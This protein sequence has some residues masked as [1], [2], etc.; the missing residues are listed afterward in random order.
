MLPSGAT[1]RPSGV[2][3][4]YGL[5]PSF[6]PAGGVS[7][8]RMNVPSARNCTITPLMIDDTNHVWSGATT[9]AFGDDSKLCVDGAMNFVRSMWSAIGEPDASFLAQPPFASALDGNGGA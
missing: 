2:P 5:A 4:L 7:T 6:S 1:A 8:V 3:V 9:T